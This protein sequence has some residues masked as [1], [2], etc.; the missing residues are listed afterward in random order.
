VMEI[1]TTAAAMAIGKIALDELV[2]GGAGELGKKL[3]AQATEKLTALG[4]YV[5]DRIRPNGRAVAAL[6]GAAEEKPEEV[7][8]LKNYLSSLLKEPEFAKQVKT[9]AEDL[10]FELT[11]IQD[12][13]S[14]VTHVHDGGTAYVT[15]ISGSNNTNIIGGQHSH[16]HGV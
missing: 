15:P 10:H 14:I 16:K 1:L 2:K 3:T 11:Q 13:S 8:A 12:N 7:Q 9:L 4:S 6:V 5:L